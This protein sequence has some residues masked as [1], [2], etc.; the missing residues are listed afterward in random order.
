MWKICSQQREWTAAL[1]RKCEVPFKFS[2]ANISENLGKMVFTW[3][4]TM[5]VSNSFLCL[6]I[7]LSYRVMQSHLDLVSHTSCH[8]IILLLRVCKS[9]CW[10]CVHLICKWHRHSYYCSCLQNV[11]KLSN[12]AYS[13][14]LQQRANKTYS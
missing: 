8:S 12:P 14:S 5:H 9:L 10:C 6:G 13:N 3:L 2:R 1:I 11:R 4:E 7:H